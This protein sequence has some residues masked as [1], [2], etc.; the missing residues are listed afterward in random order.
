MNRTLISTEDLAAHLGDR[1]Y[2]IVDCRFDL[3]NAG[4]GEREYE[5]AHIPGAGYAHL[6]RDLSGTKTGANG[7]H[8]IPDAGTLAL[9][10]GRLGIT[11]GVQVI[12]YDQDSGMYA[13]RLWWLLRWLGHDGVAVLDGGFAK[14]TAEGRATAGGRERRQEHRFA[15]NPKSHMTVDG[16][17]RRAGDHESGMAAR[18]RARAGTFSRRC[19]ANRQG[20]LAIFPARRIISSSRT[21]P[22]R[23]RSSTP[24]VLRAQLRASTGDVPV[25]RHRL[26]LRIRRNGLPQSSGNGARRAARREAVSGIVERMV[27]ADPR[28]ARGTRVTTPRAVRARVRPRARSSRPPPPLLASRE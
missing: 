5:V 6:D 16:E 4:W 15:A 25:D 11:D 27:V 20:A 1:A 26:L 23:A 7:R 14:W 22:R 8:P 17:R 3:A 19:R 18:G 2:V 21:S 12:A 24:D 9:V 13:S 28:E 10:F